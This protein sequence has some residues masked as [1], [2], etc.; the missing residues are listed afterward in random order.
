MHERF[1]IQD[2]RG[3][4]CQPCFVAWT[5]N[6]LCYSICHHHLAASTGTVKVVGR[7]V[8]VRGIL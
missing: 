6:L 8:V 2:L 7:R 4:A 3:T 5:T 1:G